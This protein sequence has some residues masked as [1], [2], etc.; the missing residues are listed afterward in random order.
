MCVYVEGCT[1]RKNR[2]EEQSKSKSVLDA[3][4]HRSEAVDNLNH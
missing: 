2:N 4:E 1:Q 3:I